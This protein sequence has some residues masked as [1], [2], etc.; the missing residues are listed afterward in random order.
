MNADKKSKT[1]SYNY[2]EKQYNPLFYLLKFSIFGKRFFNVGLIGVHRRLS[3]VTSVLVFLKWA[4]TIEFGI[5]PENAFRAKRQTAV[6]RQIRGHA[7]TR[8]DTLMQR[9]Q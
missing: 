1:P 9:H 6:G 4:L 7:R 8:H 3:A 2:T 5:V